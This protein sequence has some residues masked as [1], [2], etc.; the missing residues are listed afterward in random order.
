MNFFRQGGHF[1]FRPPVQYIYFFSAQP[2]GRSGG[3]HSR[4]AAAHYSHPAAYAF[5]LSKA[6][7]PQVGYTV[8]DAYLLFPGDAQLIW[9]MG[10]NPEK[11]GLVPLVKE[12]VDRQIL[13][14]WRVSP[15]LHALF[16]DQ[17]YLGLHQTF[18]KSVFRNSHP[19]HS[20]NHRQSF[21]YGHLVAPA[22]QMVGTR[23]A[24]RTGTDNRHL[25]FPLFG[26]LQVYFIQVLQHVITDKPLNP[27]DSYR[28]V[29]LAP[30][31][32][33]FTRMMTDRTAYNREWNL[34]PDQ[35]PGLF[36][37]ALG[38]QGHITVHIDS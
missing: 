26:N 10:A 19:H 35:F 29:N 13:T 25:F 34:L 3:V 36:E 18:G 9:I 5:L 30:L 1:G 15:Y 33:G 8:M 17:V 21:K 11:Y 4:I 16:S 12:H 23:Q 14:D 7:L 27:A 6:Y 38:R 20:A 22:G 28:F 2:E 32:G 31:A 24:G 37:F